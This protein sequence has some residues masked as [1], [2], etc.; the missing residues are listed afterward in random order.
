M[1]LPHG[2]APEALEQFIT[3]VSYE[4]ERDIFK[5]LKAERSSTERLQ[6]LNQLDLMPRFTQQAKKM[7]NDAIRSAGTDRAA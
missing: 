6:L 4:M 3:N 1:R 2:T 5:S 7:I